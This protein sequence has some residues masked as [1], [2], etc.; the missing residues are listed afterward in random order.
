MNQEELLAQLKKDVRS[1]LI[2]TKLGLEVDKLRR[3]YVT[4][5]GQPMPLKQLGFR[6]IMDMV[7]EMPDVVT[8]NIAADG[9]VW[10]TAVG[11]E[12]T[13]N[14][15]AL[16][17]NQR[18]PKPNKNARRFSPRPFPLRPSGFLPR[19]G[20]AP[21]AVP[22]DLRTQ[23]RILL[24]QGPILTSDLE[25]CFQCC[26]GYPLRPQNFGFYSTGELLDAAADLIYKHQTRLGSAVGLREHKLPSKFPIP[27]TNP[28]K[29]GQI[30][31]VPVRADRNTHM[32]DTRPKLQSQAPALVKQR[33]VNQPSTEKTT[34][35]VH[36][37]LTAATSEQQPA[38]KSQGG[39]EVC[40]N[41]GLYQKQVLK[42]EEELRQK[43]VENG[44]AGTIS[45]DL[46]DKL[47]KV[48]RES[49]DGLSVHSLPAEY[50]RLFGEDLPLQQN[51]FVS[52]T[53][54]VSA[55]ID[56]FHLKPVNDENGQQ[57][58]VMDILHSDVM[59][60]DPRATRSLDE[61]PAR[62]DFIC[63]ES[64]SNSEPEEEKDDAL[65]C[66]RI[67]TSNS[68][69]TP[70]MVHCRA[71]VPPD[72][73]QSR[74]LRK[75][76]RPSPR[77]PVQVQVEEVDSPGHFYISLSN[78][79][80]A[81]AMDNMMLEMRRCYNCPEVS[82]PYRLSAPF[83]R[84]GQVC[85]V[86]PKGLW[87]Y[88]AVIHQITSPSEVEVYFV[89]FG[90]RTVVPITRL[91]FLKSCY[92]VLPAQAVLSSL[93]GIKPPAGGWSAEATAAFQKMCCARPLVGTSDCYAGDVLR[94]YLCDT[95]TDDDI[96]VHSVLLSQGHGTACSHSAIAPLSAK[97]N[98]VSLYLGEGMVD[99]PEIKE[100]SSPKPSVSTLASVK[101]EHHLVAYHIG[102][103]ELPGLELIEDPVDSCHH[104]DSS[105]F[106][107][108]LT[109]PAVAYN[110]SDGASATESHMTL[111][112]SPCSILCAH[113][114]LIQSETD[115]AWTSD[116]DEMATPSPAPSSVTAAPCWPASE[117]EQHQLA[118]Y[119]VMPPSAVTTLSLH[120]PDLGQCFPGSP[121]K[122]R[123]S[124]FPFPLF[125]TM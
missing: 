13:R 117:D 3:D 46:K 78:S 21:L 80:E 85:C 79:E 8:M 125:G 53:E 25:S 100:E 61:P 121:L 20:G 28:R 116:L 7:K 98:L 93:A 123:K 70:Q 118:V 39:P 66:E 35:S 40:E 23:L 68:F 92:S 18:T 56:T 72:A 31:S 44:V 120:T 15:E 81:Q 57:W 99:L 38:E 101:E 95:R 2:S 30:N 77:E 107:L 37:T 52:A 102:D 114:D 54:M 86:S 10:L 74:R 59:Q 42:L 75:P 12:S 115:A 51:G 103:D 88:R 109:D 105:L 110:S 97:A 119:S 49:S 89:D 22:A 47:R 14:I 11:D 5:L 112:P 94:L 32:P 104:Q 63:S 106:N 9:N 41:D 6:N 50:E 96:Y 27:L 43:I 4:M 62:N 122:L 33:P 108:S 26:F 36:K 19:R 55:L 65:K 113:P 60:S 82:D 17:A 73:V 58:K 87:F 69:K 91:K 76:R 90:S 48:V 24:S 67:N 16:V 71:T 111:P 29:T 83:V 34:E 1:L 84:R 45:Q 64:S 124:G